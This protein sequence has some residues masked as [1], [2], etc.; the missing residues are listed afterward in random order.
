MAMKLVMSSRSAVRDGA[1]KLVLRPHGVQLA[2]PCSLQETRR[3]GSGL[4]LSLPAFLHILND[5]S[6]TSDLSPLNMNS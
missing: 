2:E 5:L 3:K 4:V 1:G 6:G